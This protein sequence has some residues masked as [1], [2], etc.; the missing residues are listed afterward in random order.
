MSFTVD[1][2]QSLKPVRDASDR[3]LATSPPFHSELRE[4]RQHR[5]Q[6][7]PCINDRVH[8]PRTIFPPLY[9]A[10]NPRHMARAAT[11]PSTVRRDQAAAIPQETR[12]V[13][14]AAFVA[15]KSR[16]VRSAAR[17]PAK[18]VPWSKDQAMSISAPT[19]QTFARTFFAKNDAES[20]VANRC[21]VRFLV[22]DR[23][24]SFSINMLLAKTGRNARSL[25]RCTPTTSG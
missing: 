13:R 25:L 4:P 23:S 3:L 14:A 12:A 10:P 18:L 2:Q 9:Q 17:P 19:A 22:R 11:R 6:D 8:S 24:K 20:I 15:A 1:D 16:R 7:H 21:L 5:T